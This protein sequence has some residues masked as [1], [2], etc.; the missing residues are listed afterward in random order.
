MMPHASTWKINHHI[1]SSC[2]ASTNTASAFSSCSEF[3]F[4]DKFLVAHHLAT[5]SSARGSYS[6]ENLAM[7]ACY[8]KN[9]QGF[10]WHH[11]NYNIYF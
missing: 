7:F 2:Y 3:R 1:T 6:I 9:C 10:L 5:S 8:R 4:K 11:I